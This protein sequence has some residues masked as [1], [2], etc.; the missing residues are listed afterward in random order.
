MQFPANI[1]YDIVPSQH[2]SGEDLLP[3]ALPVS[4]QL[5]SPPPPF[6]LLLSPSMEDDKALGGCDGRGQ[7]EPAWPLRPQQLANHCPSLATNC[8]PDFYQKCLE[9]CSWLTVIFEALGG[10]EQQCFSSKLTPS[11]ARISTPHRQHGKPVSKRKCQGWRQRET[12]LVRRHNLSQSGP[13][14]K[15]AMVQPLPWLPSA[16]MWIC[17]LLLILLTP[18]LH[19]S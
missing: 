2:L 17:S 6:P 3:G 10:V 15:A 4:Y 19:L 7:R 13:L 11:A 12:Y 8:L 1:R 18:P 5:T 9:N 16:K 14:L